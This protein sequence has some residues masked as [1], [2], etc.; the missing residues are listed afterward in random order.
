MRKLENQKE[1]ARTNRRG[2]HVGIR[3]RKKRKVLFGRK[4]KTTTLAETEQAIKIKCNLRNLEGKKAQ[5]KKE[6]QQPGRGKGIQRTNER[7]KFKETKDESGY[8]KPRTK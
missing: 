2:E 5:G 7:T 3:A 8:R 1:K 6:Y 4:N